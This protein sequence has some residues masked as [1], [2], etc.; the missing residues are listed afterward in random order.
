MDRIQSAR[1]PNEVVEWTP[2][3]VDAQRKEEEYVMALQKLETL[4][5]FDRHQKMEV[6]THGKENKMYLLKEWTIFRGK[7]SDNYHLANTTFR[8][9]S[10]AYKKMVKEYY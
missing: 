7:G 1:L 10:K 4:Q 8:R 9:L 2:L 6:G 3:R 5:K